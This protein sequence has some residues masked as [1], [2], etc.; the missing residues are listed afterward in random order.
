VS[1]LVLTAWVDASD[2]AAGAP[3]STNSPSVILAVGAA[4]E[5]GFASNF[6]Q[7]AR[8]WQQAAERGGA[9]VSA[10]GLDP[11]GATNDRTRLEERLASEV[12]DTV[13]PLWLVLIGHGTFDGKEARF[14]LRGPDFSAAE[15]ARW[16]KPAQRPLA[17]INTTAA[18]AP[19]L[20]A[21]SASNRVV[22]TATRSG[23]EESFAR[24]G[25][26]IAQALNDPG[27][28][29][30]Q[31]GQTSLLEAF[32]AASAR[33]AEFYQTA[34]RLATEH[35]LLDDNGDALGT[36]ADWF[37]GVRA[38][39]K[40]GD[41]ARPDGARAHQWHLI[42]SAAE[43]AWSAET[44]ARRDQLELELDALREKKAGFS[45]ADYY[46]EL[47][48]LLLELA[49]LTANARRVQAPR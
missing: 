46:R 18:S 21:L 15:L 45:E 9:R 35:A 6:V 12:A 43:Q 33:V 32:L 19:F 26:H 16:L 2:G 1:T 25:E 36:P 17:I 40:P 38:V 27:S 8:L 10:I 34:G 14:N 39:K 7:Q 20:N 30:D 41:K 22:I 28:D 48:A 42:P 31:D 4:G 13:S 24:F 37:R 5:P 23:N 47:E 3:R 29:L 11:E 49:R 44:R